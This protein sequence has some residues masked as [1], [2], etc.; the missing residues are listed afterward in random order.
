MPLQE[1]ET[2]PSNISNWETM[3]RKDY[4]KSD[5]VNWVNNNMLEL[6]GVSSSHMNEADPNWRDRVQE[7]WHW[8]RVKPVEK[9]WFREVEPFFDAHRVTLPPAHA[10]VEW[11]AKRKLLRD[12][13][14]FEFRV[15]GDDG[16]IVKD[17]LDIVFDSHSET[18]P[19]FIEKVERIYES[20]GMHFSP[21][22]DHAVPHWFILD[23]NPFIFLVGDNDLRKA[24]KSGE[25]FESME[26]LQIEILPHKTED[27]IIQLIGQDNQ[28]LSWRLQ[29]EV[30]AD[31][32]KQIYRLAEDLQKSGFEHYQRKLRPFIFSQLKQLTYMDSPPP[33]TYLQRSPATYRTISSETYTIERGLGDS[34]IYFTQEEFS[35]IADTQFVAPYRVAVG[36][37]PR[38]DFLFGWKGDDGFIEWD[39]TGY[40]NNFSNRQI[41]GFRQVNTFLD[42]MIPATKEQFVGVNK[43]LRPTDRITEIEGLAYIEDL[44]LLHR[45]LNGSYKEFVLV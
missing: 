41:A 1:S 27:E 31:I 32:R 7:A 42:N 28:I 19:P 34:F 6:A 3:P 2:P 22:L 11:G 39:G 4:T 5:W 37:S 38:G 45:G 26:D 25:T 17:P 21:W 43:D 8:C 36:L 14:D 44:F 30:V 24:C 18:F 20:H 12:T 33:I 9:V 13:V 10:V 40:D 16:E 23:G 35:D 15:T 29:L